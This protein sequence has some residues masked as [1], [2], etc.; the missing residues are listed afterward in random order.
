M[1]AYDI[2]TVFYRCRAM[3]IA[4][5]DEDLHFFNVEGRGYSS[6]KIPAR[7][8]ED[9]SDITLSEVEPVLI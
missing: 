1:D 4:K 5:T 6:R 3:P 7:V 8:G 9:D 2:N